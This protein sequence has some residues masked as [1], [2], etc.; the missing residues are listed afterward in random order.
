[1]GYRWLSVD[2]VGYVALIRLADEKSMNSL[3]PEMVSEL[4][5]ALSDAARSKRAIVLSGTGRGFCS[6]ANLGSLTYD[7]DGGYDA[8]ILLETHFNPL[9]LQIR[10]LEIPM[11]TAVNGLAVGVGSTLALAGDFIIASRDAYFMQAFRHVGVAPDAGTS[12]LLTRAVGRVR[13]MEMILFGE[14]LA[15]EKAL[16]W[17][18]VNRVVAGDELDRAATE[19]AQA[20]A[21]GPTKTLGEIRK[22]CWHALEASLAE[23]LTRDRL[24][25]RE[26]GKTAD[27]REAITA[28]FEKRRPVFTGS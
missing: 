16:E 5:V 28:F 6:G 21:L 18:L 14:K 10:D 26:L 11:I 15:A 2:A 1:M 4:Q 13:A 25:Q 23:Q 19:A 22:S 17:G 8:G 12:F 3:S 9:M 27:H 20:L 24:V 7:F